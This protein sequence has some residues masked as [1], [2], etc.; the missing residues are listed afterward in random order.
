MKRLTEREIIYYL[1]HRS[2]GSDQVKIPIGDD[3]ALIYFDNPR[4]TICKD[5][6]VEGTHFLKNTDPF[7]VA[8]RSVLVNIS[9]L[10]NA[11][12]LNRFAYL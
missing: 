7:Y 9:D 3:A 2:G 1:E 11:K 6:S 5:V 12:G 4:V 8:R 10:G